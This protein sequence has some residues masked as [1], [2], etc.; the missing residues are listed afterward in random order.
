MRRE[1]ADDAR[2]RRLMPGEEVWV[3]GRRAIFSAFYREGTALVRFSGDRTR[4]VVRLEK[5]DLQPAPKPGQSSPNP[6]G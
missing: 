4:R 2:K 5:V 6:M 1:M 3:D